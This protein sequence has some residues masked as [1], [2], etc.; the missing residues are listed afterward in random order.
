MKSSPPPA[1][2]NKGHGRPVHAFHTPRLSPREKIGM[3][4]YHVP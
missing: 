3:Y 4:F 1:S 2:E